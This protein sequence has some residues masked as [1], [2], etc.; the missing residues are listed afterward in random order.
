ML[1]ES[2]IIEIINHKIE[3]DEGTGYKE[4]GSSHL[5]YKSFQMNSF[6]TSRISLQ[7]TEIIYR[8]TVYVETE[9]TYF[10]D[11]PPTEYQY[12]KMILVNSK[13]KILRETELDV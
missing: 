7:E 11:N 4:G 5:S 8:Y 9:F 13:G 2:E 12:K 3:L 6:E 1:S 10:P